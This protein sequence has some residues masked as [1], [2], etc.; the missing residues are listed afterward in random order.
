MAGL[1]AGG[2]SGALAHH[3]GT[4]RDGSAHGACC[5]GRK[6]DDARSGLACVPLLG[7]CTSSFV[8]VGSEGAAAKPTATVASGRDMS[9]VGM[10][11]DDRGSIFTVLVEAGGYDDVGDVGDVDS[12]NGDFGVKVGLQVLEEGLQALDDYRTA[13]AKGLS[14]IGED[15]KKLQLTA[16]DAGK[17]AREPVPESV[18]KL[19]TVRSRLTMIEEDMKLSKL[20]VQ[21]QKMAFETQQ[22]TVTKQRRS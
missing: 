20:V 13:D 14:G 15:L 2:A 16:G 21:A 7:T 6:A 9:T 8:D 22:V 17:D 19:W 18:G 5:V 11:L 10:S 12:D 4:C 1:W 3:G